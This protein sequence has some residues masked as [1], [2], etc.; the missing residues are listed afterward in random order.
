MGE[1]RGYRQRIAFRHYTDQQQAAYGFD[2]DTG[3]KPA[4]KPTILDAGAVLWAG[5]IFLVARRLGKQVRRVAIRKVQRAAAAAVLLALFTV[6][7]CATDLRRPGRRRRGRSARRRNSPRK[8]RKRPQ[9][10]TPRLRKRTRSGPRRSTAGL[11]LVAA[12]G[13]MGD[14][15]EAILREG[16]RDVRKQL[17]AAAMTRGWP[18]GSPATPRPNATSSRP[19]R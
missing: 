1:S 18:N 17:H 5:V 6:P 8:Q 2:F 13:V 9:R 3:A 4:F 19:T 14:P 7:G 10:P 15:V 16:E 12:P 11:A